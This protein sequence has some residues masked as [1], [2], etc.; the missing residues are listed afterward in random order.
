MNNRKLIL[1]SGE[2][3]DISCDVPQGSILRP[4]LWNLY[5]ESIVRTRLSTNTE[6]LCYADKTTEELKNNSL[7]RIHEKI[8][9]R[10]S[11]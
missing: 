11:K 10:T 5:F 4:T 9:K 2:K 7:N 8:E 6:I 1:N 3:H